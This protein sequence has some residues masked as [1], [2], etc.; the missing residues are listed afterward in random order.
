MKNVR[1]KDGKPVAVGAVCDVELQRG[2]SNKR[3]VYQAEVLGIG[4]LHS[5]LLIIMMPCIMTL[6]P[7]M[8]C[9]IFSKY[10]YNVSNIP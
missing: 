8:Y 9:S 5:K 2:R 10:L 4:E 7:T 1:G 6:F 3:S